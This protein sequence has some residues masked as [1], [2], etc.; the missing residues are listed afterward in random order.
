VQTG[1][2]LAGANRPPGPDVLR[3]DRGIL[4]GEAIAGLD[5]RRLDLAVLSACDT[6][7]GEAAAGEGVYGLQRA[8][9]LGGCRNVVASLWKV[10]DQATAALMALF[11][12]NLWAKGEPPLQALRHAQLALLHHPEEVPLLANERGSPFD[13][14]VQR[15]EAPAPPTERQATT[16]AKHWAAFVLSGLGR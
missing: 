10:D 6:G 4:T 3:D 1:L 2:V 9:H 15:V 12:R 5:L 16:P 7:L 8:F 13:N 11:Y 14:V